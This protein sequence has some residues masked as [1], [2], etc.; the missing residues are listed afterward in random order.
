MQNSKVKKKLKQKHFLNLKGNF[1]YIF[2]FWKS[3]LL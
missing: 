3:N 1:K 2:S